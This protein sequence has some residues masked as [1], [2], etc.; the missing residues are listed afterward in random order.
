MQTAIVSCAPKW[1]TRGQIKYY[2]TLLTWWKR[3]RGTIRLQWFI[4][5]L[6]CTYVQIQICKTKLQ[7]RTSLV[8]LTQS[9]DSVLRIYIRANTYMLWS[10][11]RKSSCAWSVSR[12]FFLL[13]RSTVFLS[14]QSA[15]ETW[16]IQFFTDFRGDSRSYRR[17]GTAMNYRLQRPSI[18]SPT[19]KLLHVTWVT[20]RA[21]I[22]L[23]E[24]IYN[25][26]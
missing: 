3:S 7:R 15:L 1:P 11:T 20:S 12:S 2:V 21:L 10:I 16:R 23:A 13:Q 26:P 8:L 25:L 9:R 18:T 17:L 22:A 6:S 5:W 24:I 19:S 4:Y 14:A